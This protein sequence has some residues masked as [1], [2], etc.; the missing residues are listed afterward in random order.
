ME[1]TTIIGL[2]PKSS[3]KFCRE[4]YNNIILCR[5]FF[6][7]FNLTIIYY[8]SVYQ[9]L[10]NESCVVKNVIYMYVYVGRRLAEQEMHIILAK[11]FLC[12][13]VA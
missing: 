4:D 1:G 3:N 7:V 13:F 9:L 5:G 6:S 12:S 10:L 8:C 2:M 11:V